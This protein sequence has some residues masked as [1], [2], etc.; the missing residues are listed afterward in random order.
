MSHNINTNIANLRKGNQIGVNTDNVSLDKQSIP[1]GAPG[2][3]VRLI[4][5]VKKNPTVANLQ[6]LFKFYNDN[7]SLQKFIEFKT[8]GVK[9]YQGRVTHKASPQVEGVKH[10]PTFH[11]IEANKRALD[12]AITQR[13]GLTA[14]QVKTLREVEAAYDKMSPSQQNAL[15]SQH[16]DE[17]PWLR[18]LFDGFL[19]VNDK[20]EVWMLSRTFGADSNTAQKK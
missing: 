15:K 4:D 6:D 20:G 7:P 8:I 16:M 19:G 9:N 13:G 11:T 2:E 14:D 3:A 1:G 17:A 5:K 10:F 12:Q 18:M